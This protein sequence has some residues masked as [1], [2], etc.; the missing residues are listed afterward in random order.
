MRNLSVFVSLIAVFSCNSDKDSIKFRQ[1]MDHGARLYEQHCSNCHQPDG[2]G[3]G[4][5]IPPLNNNFAITNLSMTICGIKNGLHGPI[6]VDGQEYDR[7]MPSNTKL[8][9]LEIA[10]IITFITNNWKQEGGLTDVNKADSVLMR[11]P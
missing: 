7:K 4:K 5:L 11:C 6:N 2:T 10:Q 8:S 9:S 3:L 1:Y